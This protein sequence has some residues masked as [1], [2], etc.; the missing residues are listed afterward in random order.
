M[1]FLTDYLQ[2][3]HT[4]LY[5]HPHWA[6]MFTFLISFSESLAIIGSIIPG[7]VTM[8]AIGI[9][10]GS[11][12]MRIDLTLLAATLG[13]IAGDGVSYALGY[14]FRHSLPNIWP[15]YRYPHWLNYGREYFAKHGGKSVLIGRF[16]GPLRSIIPVIAGMMHMNAWHFLIAN[17]ISAIGWAIL[18]V[19]P[20]VLVGAASSEL[21]AE[22]ASKLFLLI[23]ILLLLA[24]LLTIG[25]KWLFQRINSLLKT[26][27]HQFWLWSREHPRMSYYFTLLTPETETNHYATVMLIL[28]FFLTLL[29]S[30][31]LTALVAISSF[32]HSLDDTVY[33][34]LQ[35]IRTQ[36]FDLFFIAISL[37]TSAFV[38]LALIISITV[39][40]VYY[41]D[42][43]M[44]RYWLS[45]S[46]FCT[47]L[48]FLF[49]EFISVP[50][51]HGGLIEYK[52]HLT[53]PATNLTLATSL[54]SFLI[55]YITRYKTILTL[56][57]RIFLLVILLLAGISEIYLGNNWFSSVLGAYFIGFTLCLGHWIFYRQAQLSS[58]RSQ[59]PIVFSCLVLVLTA[60]LM[61]G[62]CFK[63]IIDTDYPYLKPHLLTEET[64]W[65]QQYPL[66]PLFTTNRTGQP[67]GT[68]NLQYSGSIK[69]LEKKLEQQGWKKQ[70]SSFFLKILLRAQGQRSNAKPLVT[71]FY[72]N[73]K[74]AL[75]MTY[76]SHGGSSLWI[77]Q[78]WRSN[79]YLNHYKQPI[80]LGSIEPANHNKISSEGS[81]Q[82]FHLLTSALSGF[83]FNWVSLN[84]E[85]L[86]TG[87][88]VQPTT[89]L[90]IKQSLSKE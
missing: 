39:Y 10:A 3:L 62:F 81:L 87:K 9:L 66:L 37:F 63:K 30:I 23:I 74:P 6:L 21:S 84:K 70:S 75:I 64:W 59:S 36:P 53:Y 13:A 44:L 78:F 58:N 69:A 61:Y 65:K 83:S 89:I 16:I 24:W 82:D 15:F 35:S 49:S 2:P 67:A 79:Y 56:G 40:S 72:R 20:G 52:K 50:S 4:W 77:I 48:V 18:Y 43:R 47:I 55:F 1:Q 32:I 27:L 51:L 85:Q 25:M 90:L 45:I 11:G 34:F 7:S 80:W 54:F 86:K 73:K 38:L 76:G 60:S 42:W 22:G 28:L 8:T 5:T 14:K 17:I 41:K 26:N 33:L 19:M 12:V 29:F 88:Q 68:F 57:I 46:F 71:Q 31:V